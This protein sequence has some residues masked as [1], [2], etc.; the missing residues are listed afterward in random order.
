MEPN[1]EPSPPPHASEAPPETE[2][3][4]R[5]PFFKWLALY[6]APPILILLL[7]LMIFGYVAKTFQPEIAE[8][9]QP[10]VL[11]TVNVISVEPSSIRVEVSSQGTVSARTTT[12]LVSE[13]SGRVESISPALFAGGFFRKGEQLA[14]IE[15]TDYL[16][17]LAAA[18]S[19]LAEANLVF[20][21]EKALAEQAKQDWEDMGNLGQPDPL[22]L[23]QPQLER[24]QAALDAAQAAVETA[25]RDL[26]RTIIRAPYD[27]RVMEK[28]IDLG[29]F[30]IAR[31]SP[32]ATIYSV[33]VAEIQLPISL[34]DTRFLHL[35]ESY[36]DAEQSYESKPTVTIEASYGGR[37]YQ[38]N[39][40]IDRAEGNI[41]P[42]TRLLNVV[43]QVESPY[44]KDGDTPPLK[45][46]TFVTA[47][48]HGKTLPE[49]FVLPR[50]A[51]REN[52]T[53]YV[54]TDENR[55]EIRPVT[56]YQK[57]SDMVILSEGLTAGE[58]VCLTPMQFVV[59]DME[60]EIEGESASDAVDSN[61]EA[62]S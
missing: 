55:I 44:Q 49:A 17:G 33:D 61:T 60:V 26:D 27:G 8:K 36:S 5:P 45:V 1:Q 21:Q 43:A 19:R 58:R 53:V 59:D 25:R 37:S 2:S 22:V 42:Q 3:E 48:I 32:I 23:R 35:P 14:R 13:V 9:V 16:A 10:R 46:G 11:P 62:T 24:A 50:K 39:G 51:L 6:V 38:W 41:D 40:V 57:K 34:N 12:T 18:E 54:V 30:L 52:D 29:Q 28:R 47:T 31:S 7:F 56:V 15:N 4:Q 20:Q